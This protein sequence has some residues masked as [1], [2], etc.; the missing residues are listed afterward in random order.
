V[1]KWA[2]KALEQELGLLLSNYDHYRTIRAIFE[3]LYPP[4]PEDKG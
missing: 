1:L 2:F 3:K 4:I